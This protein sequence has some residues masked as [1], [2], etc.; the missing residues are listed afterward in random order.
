MRLLVVPLMLLLLYVGFLLGQR[1]RREAVAAVTDGVL[2]LLRS[3]RTLLV[4]DPLSPA[5]PATRAVV[6]HELEAYERDVR[7]L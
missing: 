4:E 2:P 1:S 3:V 6:Q 7:A 5:Y